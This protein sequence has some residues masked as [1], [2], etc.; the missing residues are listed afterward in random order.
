MQSKARMTFQ[1]RWYASMAVV[2]I[3]AGVLIPA[4]IIASGRGRASVSSRVVP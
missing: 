3:H 2:R 4:K 1:S